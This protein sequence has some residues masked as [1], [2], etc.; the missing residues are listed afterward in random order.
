M[1]NN[2]VAG[3]IPE[4]QAPS[5]P[6][7]GMADYADRTDDAASLVR[8]VLADDGIPGMSV[9]VVTPEETVWVDG[10]GSRDLAENLPATPETVYGVGSVTKSFAALAVLQLRDRGALALDDAV[11]DYAGVDLRND[12]DPVTI[13]DLLTH[14]SGLPSLGVSEALIARQA[15]IGEAGVPLGDR[16]DFHAHVAGAAGEFAPR[17]DRFMYCNTGYML[18]GEVVEAVSGTPFADY[19]EAEILDPLG[20]D[21]STFDGDTFEATDDRMTPYYLDDGPEATDL[22]VREL[23]QAPGG[24]LAPVTDLARYVRMQL[25]GGSLD[26]REVVAADSLAEAHAGHVETDTGPYGYGW[27]HADRFGETVVGHSGSIGVASA[28]VGF[29]EGGDLGVAVAANASPDYPLAAV[30]HGVLAAVRGLDPADEVPLFARRDRFDGIV[31]DYETYR[32]VREATIERDGQTLRLEFT[33]AFGGDGIS[34]VPADP[35][36]SEFFALSSSGERKPVE[37]EVGEDGGVDCFYDRWR[38]HR[39]D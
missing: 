27:G 17:G 15:G 1:L 33:D 35:E 34:V 14:S 2:M 18:L 22:P 7:S 38:L 29:V 25:R 16:D 37:F 11:D 5:P 13:Q 30:G 26:G 36:A 28:Y 10:F 19:V 9:A 20:M 6:A 31:G 24:L 3:A 12:G 39:V 32:G 4:I 21:R 8:D 23:S